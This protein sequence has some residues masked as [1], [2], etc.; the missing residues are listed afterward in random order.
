MP[1][2]SEAATMYAKDFKAF[3]LRHMKACTILLALISTQ[4]ITYVE[5]VDDPGQIWRILKDNTA[6]YGCASH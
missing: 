2:S 5:Y 6:S 4:L 1:V 3:E